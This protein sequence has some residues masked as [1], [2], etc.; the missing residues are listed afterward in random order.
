MKK[1]PFVIAAFCGLA[2]VSLV[3]AQADAPPPPPKVLQIFRETVKPGHSAAHANTE[4]GWPAAFAKADAPGHY[5]A[6]TST[7]GPNEAWF[8]TGYESF[9]AY[10]KDNAGI[11]A[12][13]AL[14]AE[15]D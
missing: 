11:E 3:S 2:S 5:L 9:A 1:S 10:E 6:L 14:S 8:I 13:A 4:A 12:N 15:T 7:S